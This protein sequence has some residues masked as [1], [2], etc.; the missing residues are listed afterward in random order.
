MIFQLL[1]HI[2][3]TCGSYQGWLSLH[4]GKDDTISDSL[5]NVALIQKEIK[6]TLFWGV[7]GCVT[8]INNYWAETYSYHVYT[9]HITIKRIR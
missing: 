6:R 1:Y 5:K 7:N 4:L 3:N 9:Y 8:G 2:S